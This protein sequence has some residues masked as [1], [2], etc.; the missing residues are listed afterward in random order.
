M[1]YLASIVILFGIIVG[2][3][4]C[5]DNTITDPETSAEVVSTDASRGF[6]IYIADP[7]KEIAE[8]GGCQIDLAKL[9]LIGEPLNESQIDYYDQS[10][11]LFKLKVSQYDWLGG[12]KQVIQTARA[13]GRGYYAMALTLDG[14]AIMAA[15]TLSGLSSY[16]CPAGQISFWE[17]TTYGAPN[18]GPNPRSNE[19]YELHLKKSIASTTSKEEIVPKID[20]RLLARL[21]AVDKL[22]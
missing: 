20:G 18:P 1:K 22:K 19:S 7:G 11:G 15:Y 17:D 5:T 8:G 3:S 21:K 6:A 2:L 13:K 9:T 12:N 16:I 10:T 4:S 14:K